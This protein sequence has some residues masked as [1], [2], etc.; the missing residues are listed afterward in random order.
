MKEQV[1]YLS[2]V[3]MCRLQTLNFNLNTLSWSSFWRLPFLK[4]SLKF[5]VEH[6]SGIYLEIS[7]NNY[8]QNH[9]EDRYIPGNDKCWSGQLRQRTLW[10]AKRERER[11]SER[12]KRWLKRRNKTSWGE[13]GKLPKGRSTYQ[14]D[15][16]VF[17]GNCKCPCD[18]TIP[19]IL[20]TSLKAVLGKH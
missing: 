17:K 18:V 9:E 16:R 15:Q 5:Y 13:W 8:G 20:E 14:W 6:I 11:E 7:E 19:G 10:V 4:K 3:S 12:E 2:Q 1:L